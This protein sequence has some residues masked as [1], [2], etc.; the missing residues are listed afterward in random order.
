MMMT[1]NHQQLYE[2]VSES[3]RIAI[4]NGELK[5][6]EWIRQKRIS[7]AM[8][9]S[10]IPVRE[11]LKQ[12]AAEGLVEHVPYRGVRVVR[13]TA[14]DIADIYAQR[15]CLESRAARA[16]AEHILPEEIEYLHDLQQQIEANL[17]PENLQRYRELNRQ[18]HQ[19]IYRLSQREYL[20]RTLD[21]MWSAFPSM[22]FSNF[23]QTSNQPL[24]TRDTTDLEEH[25][26]IIEALA[27][28][29]PDA[30]EKAVL[31]HVQ[32]AGKAFEETVISP[33]EKEVNVR[34]T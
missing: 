5:P 20:I 19:T 30:A 15:A 8:G 31:H 18:F 34:K 6:G 4:L 27:K 23:A 22:L 16:A 17:N 3:L 10:Q 25:Q 2:K 33:S 9:V 26:A 13:Y 14:E 21:Q 11:A 1:S 24:Q 29:D 32:S 7:E 28:G 12:L